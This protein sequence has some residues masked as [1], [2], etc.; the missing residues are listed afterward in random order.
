MPLQSIALFPKGRK[1]APPLAGMAFLPWQDGGVVLLQGKL[2]LE[3]MLVFLGDVISEQEFRKIQKM[4]WGDLQVSS[5]LP[6]SGR[7]YHL[8]L[9]NIQQRG[10]LDVRHN[11]GKIVVQKFADEGT[12]TP[13][14]A[15]IFYGQMKLVH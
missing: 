9:R 8:L 13:F 10:G 7:Q 12:G 2:P 14:M 15:R 11:E 3:G 1:D 4:T 5:I 6:L